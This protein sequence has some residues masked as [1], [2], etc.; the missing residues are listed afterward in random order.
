MIPKAVAD[1]VRAYFEDL[2][3]WPATVSQ[4]GSAKKQFKLRDD[5]AVEARTFMSTV[6]GAMLTA[7]ALDDPETFACISRAAIERLTSA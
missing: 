1:E 4:Q 5:A 6:H 7:R 2:I 3:A